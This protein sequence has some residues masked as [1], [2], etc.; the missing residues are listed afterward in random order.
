MSIEV[1]LP[2]LGESITHARLSQ[3]LKKE[4]E[5][6]AQGEVIAE[7]ETDKTSVE[8]ESPGEGVLSSIHIPAG[9]DKVAVNALLAV[10]DVGA[11]APA[12][13]PTRPDA[14][15][16]VHIADARP[17]ERPAVPATPVAAAVPV[18][19]VAYTAAPA[20]PPDADISA[21]PL[22][23]RMAHA[24][25]IPLASIRGTGSGGRIMKEDVEAAI[26]PRVK[27]AP[28]PRAAAAV[29]AHAFALPSDDPS[30]YEVQ[31]LSPMRRVSAERLTQSKQAIPHFYLR[32]ECAMDAVSGVR[33][34]INK[35]ASDKISFTAFTIRALALALKRVPAANAMW[36][37]GSVRLYKTVDLAVAVNTPQGL[38]APIVRG[39]E[40]RTVAAINREIKA[41][42]EKARA[43]KL[44][45]EEY[46]GGTCTVSNLGMFGITS[47][48]PIVNPPQTCIV[49]VG[50]IEQR[51]VVRDGALAV[52]MMMTA[53]LAAD[54]RALDG[55]TGAEFL[56]AFKELIE[57]PLLLLL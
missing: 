43:G 9:T 37:D 13:A 56:A 44:K 12:G 22:A 21:S 18:T 30:R 34:E 38:I 14:P 46:T 36:A 10:L 52:G 40:G 27:P 35:R 39:A 32:A 6:V 45:P 8:I 23:R 17:A 53:T 5:R 33:T 11:S 29:Q 7:V 3:W 42:A 31:A 26:A 48:Y 47:L 1:R 28:S 24:A 54:H 41:L 16:V 25:G 2:Q 20:M 57:D 15:Q 4:G 19:A 51:P 55:A 49:G 50:A